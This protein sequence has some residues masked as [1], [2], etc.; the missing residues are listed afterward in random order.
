MKK[1][2]GFLLGVA[3]SAAT[4]LAVGIFMH[5]FAMI[6]T[7]PV[8]IAALVV[9]FLINTWLLF[10]GK[11]SERSVAPNIAAGAVIGVV[12]WVLLALA[13]FFLTGHLPGGSIFS[14]DFLGR[15]FSVGLAGVSA[16]LVHRCVK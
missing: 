11:G 7:G 12:L 8:T 15:A 2:I 14:G 9:G 10:I 3:A 1:E 16:A 5:G 6:L 4:L 13:A